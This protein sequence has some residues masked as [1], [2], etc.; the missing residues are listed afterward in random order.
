MA[1]EPFNGW[2]N[3]ETWM[4]GLWFNDSFDADSAESL[5]ADSYR[6]TVYDYVENGM[7]G[8]PTGFIS[9]II[10]GFLGAVNWA[11][12][13]DSVREAHGIETEEA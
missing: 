11:E 9:D 13:A 4:V 6:D 5:C 8:G 3:Y 12:L 2:T 1:N 10:D 7:G